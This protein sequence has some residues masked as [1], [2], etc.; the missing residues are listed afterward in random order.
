MKSLVIMALIGGSAVYLLANES[1]VVSNWLA[2]Q[3]PEAQMEKITQTLNQRVDKQVNALRQQITASEEAKRSQMQT[4]EGKL[5]S[6]EQQVVLLAEQ[7]AT[8]KAAVEQLEQRLEKQIA[9]QIAQ[10]RAQEIAQQQQWQGEQQL[11]VETAASE[12]SF[13]KVRTTDVVEVGVIED[14][15]IANISTSTTSAFESPSLLKAP[16]MT[17][18]Q[19]RKALQNLS[20]RMALKALSMGR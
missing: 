18:L 14:D 11:P 12:T 1:S 10:E 17:N 7:K 2:E 8:A 20:Q 15:R 4:L 3:S 9:Q 5:L 13:T 19:R 16:L 6:M